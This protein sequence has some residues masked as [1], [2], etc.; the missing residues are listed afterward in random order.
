MRKRLTTQ[1][2][3]ERANKVHNGKYDYSK[4][5]YKTKDDK[6]CI[7]CP[8]HGEFWQVANSHI[9]G[10]GCRLCAIDAEKSNTEEFVAKANL[11]W[12]GQITFDKVNYVDNKTPIIATCVKHGDFKTTP[13]HILAG[14]GCPICKAHNHRKIKY[15]VGIIDNEEYV[16]HNKSFGV[17]VDMLRRCYTNSVRG[18]D[19]YYVHKD[20]LVYSNFKEWF[21]KYYKEGYEI[22]KDWLN[23]G[24]KIYGPNTCCLIPRELN[25][26]LV[27]R[28]GKSNG[29]PVGVAYDKRSK[30][31]YA[32]LCIGRKNIIK[33][34]GY[35]TKE[36][37]FK[38]YKEVKEDYIKQLALK[39][40]DDLPLE[41][42]NAIYNYKI[43]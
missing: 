33:A 8:I 42:F 2:F 1:E 37:A 7:I 41:I 15:G 12:S 23:K 13:A 24:E 4:V 26:F 31:Y 11:K 10:C 43:N 19:G 39:Y 22:D 6:V 30:R 16:A 27:N 25:G 36:E 20:W 18:Y 38:K 21:D 17:W 40:K 9:R 5:E 29:L 28:K 35:N 32:R 14:N 34:G 3:I